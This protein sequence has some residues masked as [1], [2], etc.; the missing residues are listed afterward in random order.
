M[1]NIIIEHLKALRAGQDRIEH[2]VKEVKARLTSLESNFAGGRRDT[3][4]QQEDIYRQQASMDRLSER[5]DRLEK[6]V[7]I[8]D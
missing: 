3:V 6:R 7:D 5:I 2:E 4:L 1:D 8:I